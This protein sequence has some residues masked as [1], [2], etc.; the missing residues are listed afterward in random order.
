[1]K[2]SEE[3]LKKIIKEE[4]D[5]AVEEGL[6]DRLK[7]RAASAKGKA[8][9]AASKLGAKAAG[10]LGAPEAAA[11]LERAA[12]ARKGAAQDK[13]VVVLRKSLGK[14]IK[15]VQARFQKELQAALIDAVKLGLDDNRA[16][17]IVYGDLNKVNVSLKQAIETLAGVA[18][19]E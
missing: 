16:Q 10:A 2:I 3:R 11:E 19:E 4:I 18:A 17:Q 6:L 5:A 8:A 1:M 15:K 7:A 12:A 9:S 13:E 14:R